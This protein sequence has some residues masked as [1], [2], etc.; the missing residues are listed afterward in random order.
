[1]KVIPNLKNGEILKDIPGYEKLYA[2]TNRGRVWSYGNNR[3]YGQRWLKPQNYQNYLV[4]GLYKNNACKK[5]RVHRLV[6]MAFLE[7]PENKP[8][9]NHKDFNTTNNDVN[10]L[11][12]CTPAENSA[13]SKNRARWQNMIDKGTWK[14]GA[15]IANDKE[16]WRIA[17]AACSA[18]QSWKK[19]ARKANELQTY[20][21]AQKAAK[22]ANKKAVKLLKAGNFIAIFSSIGEAAQYAFKNGWASFSTLKVFKKSRDCTLEYID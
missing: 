16:T 6:A 17:V 8:F 1:M 2:I 11:E 12:W 5:W 4:V 15:K 18:K 21:I 14:K 22:E 7:N 13:Y 10:N 9:I 3:N 19:G 20:K